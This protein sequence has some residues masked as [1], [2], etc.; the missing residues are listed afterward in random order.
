MPT[1]AAEPHPRDNSKSRLM[2]AGLRLS[3]SSPGMLPCS[4]GGSYHFGI[5]KPC[6]APWMY[7]CHLSP[8][9]SDRFLDTL[10][11]LHGSTAMLVADPPYLELPEKPANGGRFPSYLSKSQVDYP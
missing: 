5:R 6:S 3:R 9:E 7:G 2:I 11:S 8:S 1:I 4:G 10:W